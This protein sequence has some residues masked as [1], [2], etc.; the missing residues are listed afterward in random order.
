MLDRG[1]ELRHVEVE[2]IRL[3]DIGR[4]PLPGEGP[5]RVDSA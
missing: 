1:E 3:L 2:E 4:V 5:D